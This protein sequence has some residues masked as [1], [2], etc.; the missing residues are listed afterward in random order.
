[1]RSLRLSDT[2][3][4]THHHVRIPLT[5]V[6]VLGGEDN[7]FTQQFVIKHQQGTVEELELIIPENVKKSSASL[8]RW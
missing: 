5:R 7:A 3:E 6:H 8:W 1:M 2:G 4:G